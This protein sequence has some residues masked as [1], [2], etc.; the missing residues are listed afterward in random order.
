MNLKWYHKSPDQ[1]LHNGG[2]SCDDPYREE[3]L[4][5]ILKL[6]SQ[7]GGVAGGGSI[8]TH[9]DVEISSIDSDDAVAK[10]D[11]TVPWQ[12]DPTKLS[13]NQRHKIN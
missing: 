11:S 9:K 2:T 13:K 10:V 6:A 4:D 12:V 8:V 7:S 1:S 3:E 5:S